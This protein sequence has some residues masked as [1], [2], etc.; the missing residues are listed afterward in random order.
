[1]KDVTFRHSWNAN[2]TIEQEMEEK[3]GTLLVEHDTSEDYQ[4]ERSLLFSKN[5]REYVW[6]SANGC[7]CWD[8]DYDGWVLT[9][10]ELRK[11]A[12]KTYQHKYDWRDSADALVAKW[13]IDNIG[14]WL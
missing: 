6:L 5:G 1:M 11:L 13:V 12:E 7:S 14:P 3:F 8:G 4:V 9:E 10:D 2:Q